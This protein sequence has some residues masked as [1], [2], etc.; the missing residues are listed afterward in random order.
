MATAN[1]PAG[2]CI[3]VLD[4]FSITFQKAWMM[5]EPKASANAAKGTEAPI[6]PLHHAGSRFR[7]APMGITSTFP[8]ARWRKDSTVVPWITSENRGVHDLPGSRVPPRTR[9]KPG[10]FPGR[11]PGPQAGQPR[12]R[13][14]GAHPQRLD[15]A[16]S[17]LTSRSAASRPKAVAEALST[18]WNRAGKAEKTQ[19]TERPSMSRI[20][21]RKS[22]AIAT[23]RRVP[24]PAEKSR[25]RPRPWIPPSC[26]GLAAS[27]R[28]TRVRSEGYP[29]QQRK[30]TRQ[31]GEEQD[32]GPE[33]PGS[34]RSQPNLSRYPPRA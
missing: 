25:E 24:V 1:T 32:L 8:R 6:P 3:Q 20:S 31:Q 34:S 9:W 23:R 15:R 29:G 17:V 5:A 19:E 18:T 22:R 21:L 7:L 10:Q 16:R 27:Q 12:S 14:S 13:V 4:R 2:S 28:A 33:F 30:N 26:R 11:I